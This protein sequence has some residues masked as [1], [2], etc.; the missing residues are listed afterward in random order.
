MNRWFDCR[1]THVLPEL[2]LRF[3]A[4]I[5]DTVWVTIPAGETVTL[6]YAFLPFL[7][8]LRQQGQCCSQRLDY[9]HSTDTADCFPPRD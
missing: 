5:P 3:P 1:E 9:K 4:I 7:L 2:I 8:D 6:N